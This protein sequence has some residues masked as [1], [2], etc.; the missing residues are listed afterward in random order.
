MLLLGDGAELA[1]Q[2]AVETVE[3]VGIPPARDLLRK[4]VDNAVPIYI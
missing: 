1:S 3:G 4:L 2:Q